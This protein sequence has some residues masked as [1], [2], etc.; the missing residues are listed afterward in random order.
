VTGIA[1]A[2]QAQ[3]AEMSQKFLSHTRTNNS[4]RECQCRSGTIVNYCVII[5]ELRVAMILA[6]RL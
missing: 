4:N 6:G 2:Q 3:S 5:V 1:P